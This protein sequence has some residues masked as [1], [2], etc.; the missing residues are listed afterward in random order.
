M[1]EV[2]NNSL[3]NKMSYILLSVALNETRVREAMMN[4]LFW[5]NEG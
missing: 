5:G 2:N 3:F 1:M 4:I